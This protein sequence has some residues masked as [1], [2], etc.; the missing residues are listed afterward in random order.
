M[1]FSPDVREA[2]PSLSLGPVAEEASF[3][4][5]HLASVPRPL[6]APRV[7]AS[8]PWGRM[9]S[10]GRPDGERWWGWRGEPF[11]EPSFSAPNIP[12]AELAALGGALGQ[13]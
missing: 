12:P 1:A 4:L 7:Q 8:V 2:L 3:G 5:P 13:P 6:W 11:A 10:A 9:R